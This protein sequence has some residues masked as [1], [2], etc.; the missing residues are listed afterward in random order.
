MRMTDKI[1]LLV[2]RHSSKDDLEEIVDMI[3]EKFWIEVVISEEATVADA[4]MPMII[5]GVRRH[6]LQPR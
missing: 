5:E 4:T 2:D 6:N 1:R 3:K